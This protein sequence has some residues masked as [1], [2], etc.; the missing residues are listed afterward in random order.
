MNRVRVMTIR[1]Q[2]QKKSRRFLAIALACWLLIVAV[3]LLVQ[4]KPSPAVT[5]IGIGGFFIAM[6]FMFF[7]VRCSCCNAN[8][9]K[10]GV[11]HPFGVRTKRGIN[12]CPYCGVN[13]DEPA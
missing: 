6:L 7:L 4:G 9:G 1:E 8:L 11:V 12:F 3:S 5:A 10:F 13:L 2:M